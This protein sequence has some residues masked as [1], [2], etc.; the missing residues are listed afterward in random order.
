MTLDQHDLR[1]LSVLQT[2]ARIPIERLS[3]Q[4]GLSTAS[5]QRRL[6]RLRQQQTIAAEVAVVSPKRV[7][8][9]MTFMVSVELERD[10]LR[11]LSEFKAKIKNEPRI[12]Q[13]YYV[14]GDAD[15][16]LIV[17]TRDMEEF[18]SFVQEVFY[19]DKNVRRY[20]TSVVMERTKVGLE[21]PLPTG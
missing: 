7:G 21:L 2:N 13:C 19:G 11:F 15:F 12:Q 14:T 18:N 3:E 6:K 1:I 20:K 17:M 9:A 4:V 16:M 8:L 10:E 5:V